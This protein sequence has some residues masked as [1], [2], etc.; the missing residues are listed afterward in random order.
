MFSEAFPDLAQAR[1]AHDGRDVLRLEVDRPLELG[2]RAAQLALLEEE[3]GVEVARASVVR[4]V[5]D[6]LL[7]LGERRV[8]VPLEVEPVRPGDRVLLLLLVVL[9]ADLRGHRRRRRRSLDFHWLRR[10]AAEGDEEGEE[11][12]PRL[13]VVHLGPADPNSKRD[14]LKPQF[15]RLEGARVQGCLQPDGPETVRPRPETVRSRPETVRSPRRAKIELF[16][17]LLPEPPEP[18]LVDHVVKIHAVGE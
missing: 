13:H 5:G 17:P 16:P 1:P 14:G 15:R 11:G 3:V 2:R 9:R 4:V 6:R 10:G 7:D 18:T 12:R 8:E